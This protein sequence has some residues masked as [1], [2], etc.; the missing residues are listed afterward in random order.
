MTEKFRK[1]MK[2]W[3][4]SK[5]QPDFDEFLRKMELNF[6]WVH[7]RGWSLYV[8]PSSMHTHGMWG[9][10]RRLGRNRLSRC[11]CAMTDKQVQCPSFAGFDWNRHI[12]VKFDRILIFQKAFSMLE[13]GRANARKNCEEIP[14]FL[15]IDSFVQT[16][17]CPSSHWLGWEKMRKNELGRS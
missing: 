17:Q 14:R 16:G 7:G 2:S 6:I 11:Q 12:S 4:F 10:G 15:E 5:I 13:H 9:W 8:Y 3:G 1:K